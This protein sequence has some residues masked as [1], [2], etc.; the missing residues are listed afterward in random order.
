MFF[1]CFS[2][3]RA[4]KRNS[5]M[6]KKRSSS[7]HGNRQTCLAKRTRRAPRKV[8]DS[9]STRSA[10][11]AMPMVAHAASLKVERNGCFS[12]N[13]VLFVSGV[14]FKHVLWKRCVLLTGTE[15][16]NWCYGSLVV[17]LAGI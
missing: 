5:T 10:G 11:T 3:I 12:S 17:P 8:A 16:G 9:C 13:G 1:H 4:K 15:D 2:L 7:Q 14:L 6:R